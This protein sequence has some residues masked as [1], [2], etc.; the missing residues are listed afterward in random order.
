MFYF[1]RNSGAVITR[2][3]FNMVVQFGNLWGD[4]SKRLLN[5]MTWLHAPA[6]ALTT[7]RDRNI[8]DNYEFNMHNFQAFITGEYLRGIER[9]KN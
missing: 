7:F 8:K 1:L 5:A 3:T 9:D 4:P 2:E 6:I